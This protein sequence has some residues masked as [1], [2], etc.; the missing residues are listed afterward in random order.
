[1]HLQLEGSLVRQAAQHLIHRQRAPPRQLQVPRHFRP[2]LGELGVDAGQSQMCQAVQCCL[3][4]LLTAAL[5]AL[6][7]GRRCPGGAAGSGRLGSGRA[8]RPSLVVRACCCCTAPLLLSIQPGICHRL[9]RLLGPLHGLAV[10]YREVGADVRHRQMGRAAP[11]QGHRP[12]AQG[13]N[14]PAGR[15]LSLPPGRSAE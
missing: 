7:R 13:Q 9:P 3:L 12:Q 1:M 10:Q 4:R 5:L 14:Q 15:T 2:E 8:A 11:P 6:V